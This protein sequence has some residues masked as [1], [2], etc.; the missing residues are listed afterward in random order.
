MALQQTPETCVIAW[1]TSNNEH[2]QSS[3]LPAAPRSCP[4]CPRCCCCVLLQWF[5][6]GAAQGRADGNAGGRDS[7][8]PCSGM[9]PALQTPHFPAQLCSV[10]GR[11]QPPPAQLEFNFPRGKDL[12]LPK[13]PEEFWCFQNFFWGFGALVPVPLR[14][15]N[16]QYKSS[17]VWSFQ[18]RLKPIYWGGQKAQKESRKTAFVSVHSN[19]FHGKL[20]SESIQSW[21]HDAGFV[22]VG[23]SCYRRCGFLFCEVL[24]GF[25]SFVI[26]LLISVWQCHAWSK[27][28]STERNRTQPFPCLGPYSCSVGKKPQTIPVP[29]NLPSLIFFNP[30]L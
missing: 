1:D 25:E 17:C 23:L 18:I 21:V 16:M 14:V 13:H 7:P 24:K 19:E 28:G 29:G 30:D 4:S 22:L 12:I 15:T 8:A 9:F 11:L 6:L 2:F 10:S 27:Q 26:L 3:S 20:A 5:V